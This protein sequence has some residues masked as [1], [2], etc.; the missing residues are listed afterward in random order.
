MWSDKRRHPC[1]EMPDRIENVCV[2]LS[3]IRFQ[4]QQ[5]IDS[6]EGKDETDDPFRRGSSI[7]VTND[8]STLVENRLEG[9]VIPHQFGFAC[10]TDAGVDLPPHVSDDD[11]VLESLIPTKLPEHVEVLPRYPTH[12]KTGDP[13]EVKDASERD[14][15]FVS[16]WGIFHEKGR[17]SVFFF[18]T[19]PDLHARG[20]KEGCDHLENMCVAPRGIVESRSVD[21]NDRMS[22]Q[23]E[24]V[25][26]LHRIRARSQP[27]AYSEIRFAD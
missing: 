14:T 27:V 8:F 7:V 18:K 21:Q 5:L 17:F 9:K 20:F 3:F 15:F 12:P 2:F 22:V 13:V 11:N 19:E 10:V 25:C 26:N 1:Y 4:I 24:R 16:T 6:L 23:I